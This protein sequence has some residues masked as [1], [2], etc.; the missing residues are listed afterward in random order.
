LGR[1]GLRLSGLM[2]SGVGSLVVG[3]V[4]W[5]RFHVD[6]DVDGFGWSWCGR[7]RGGLGGVR[8]LRFALGLFLFLILL[9]FLL[10]LGVVRWV[11]LW[12]CRCCWPLRLICGFGRLVVGCRGWWTRRGSGH[13]GMGCCLA[14]FGLWVREV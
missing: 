13:D 10:P 11:R 1:E 14:P 7:G 2:S 6:V 5:L 9:V 4:V 12:D 8:E 3:I